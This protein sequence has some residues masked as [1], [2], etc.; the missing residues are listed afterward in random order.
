MG[1]SFA[2]LRY[3]LVISSITNLLACT[4]IVQEHGMA[5]HKSGSQ[6]QWQQ[7]ALCS[8]PKCLGVHEADLVG[9]FGAEYQ[10]PHPTQCAGQLLGQADEVILQP[11]GQG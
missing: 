3:M 1:I 11:G 9:H 6:C 5:W 4:S 7:R 8:P 10:W 2:E